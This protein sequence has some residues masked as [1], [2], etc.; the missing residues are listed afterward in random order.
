MEHKIFNSEKT[1]YELPALFLGE[2]P[3]LFDTVNKAYPRIWKLYK[4]LKKMD[5][6]ENEFDYSGCNVEFKTCDKSTYNL[7]IKTLTWQW[8]ADS[9]ASRTILPVVSA[10]LSSSELLA[11]Y[12][13]VTKNEIVHAATYS[14][15]VRSS[16]DDPKAVLK[17]ILAEKNALSRLNTVAKYMGEVYTVS[18]QY[19]LG[20][21]SKDDPVVQDACV[22]FYA[23]MFALERIQFMASFAVT[24]DICE[25]GLFNAIG[26]AVQK[27][28]QEE[29]E[30]HVELGREIHRHVDKTWFKRNIDKIKAVFDEVV[31]S[32][33]E[34]I[35]YLFKDTERANR[36]TAK[37]LEQWLFYNAKDAYEYL[38]IPNDLFEFP[39]ENPYPWMAMWLD[40]SKTQSSPQEEDNGGYKVGVVRAND[41]GIKFAINF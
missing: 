24:F 6:D 18:H 28:A 36:V 4:T 15:I 5:W 34:W 27:I 17:D 40:I 12:A 16:F 30:I 39:E 9:V 33:R 32:E 20:M 10:F 25:T 37:S 8:E 21:L 11:A 31:N 3:G 26:K 38:G 35:H 2:D 14:E 23:I 22:M 41:V 7:M 1:D 19:A 13:E 29:F